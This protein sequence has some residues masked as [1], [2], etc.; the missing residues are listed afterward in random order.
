MVLDKKIL[1]FLPL[2]LLNIS[3]Y[4]QEYSFVQL[5]PKVHILP[6]INPERFY[7]QGSVEFL[8]NNR[9]GIEL[10]YGRRISELN[11]EKIVIPFGESIM[12]DVNYYTRAYKN[13]QRFR[14][15]MLY[16]VSIRKIT[17]SHNGEVDWTAPLDSSHSHKVR[18]TVG[19]NKTLIIFGIK[20]GVEFY[21]FKIFGL[22]LF[23]E[24]GLKYKNQNI[25]SAYYDKKGVYPTNTSPFLL[26]LLPYNGYLPN[27]N[28]GARF[29]WLLNKKK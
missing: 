4:S 23:I 9:I 7:L 21:F 17:D 3:A 22:D 15:R 11:L 2:L 12:L 25:Q 26:D 24:P 8:L 1:L 18:E 6:L 5:K 14:F 16:G 27:F 13:S 20:A 28:L 10:G 29:F 19:V